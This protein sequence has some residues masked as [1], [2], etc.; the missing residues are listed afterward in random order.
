MTPLAWDLPVKL[1][2]NKR[3]QACLIASAP[4]FED[5][6]VE[7]DKEIM[8]FHMAFFPEEVDQDIAPV[9]DFIDLGGYISQ[10][11]FS[12][13]F[14]K[15]DRKQFG[16]LLYQVIDRLDIAVEEAGDIFL[17]EIRVLD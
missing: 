7:V 3:R 6:I 17:K 11:P 15:V 12:P 8:T 9:D 10:S 5:R 2:G 13:D 16:Q 4:E 1:G 14:V